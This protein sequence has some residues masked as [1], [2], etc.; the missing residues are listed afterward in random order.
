[1]KKLSFFVI[2]FITLLIQPVC[3]FSETGRIVIEGT[4]DSQALLRKLA[5]AFEKT[6]PGICIEIPDSIGSSGGIKATAS[7]KCDLGRVARPIKANEK[8]Y[9]L[10]FRCFAYAPVV[11]AMNQ[12]VRGIDNLTYSQ[13]LGI[14]SGE[15]E[16]WKSL[17]GPEGKIY[18]IN[19][20]QGDSSR[21]ALEETIPG[22]RNIQKPAGKTVYTTPEAFDILN[23]YEGTIG[24][25]PLAMIKG[26]NVRIPRINGI[27][28][29]TENVQEGKYP[30]VVPL[31]LVWKG[32]LNAH[33][34]AF[35]TFLFSPE[36]KK[37][38]EGNGAIPVSKENSDKIV[39]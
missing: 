39:P 21:T 6:H 36:G 29:S 27:E 10:T 19:R 18:I 34:S 7:G 25:V 38:I 26:S 22:F 35:V 11:F 14:Y 3:G 4:G 28:P 32:G 24:Y 30:N 37:I 1:M 33:S 17:G 2:C 16:D 12:S 20:E 31:G 23:Q 15:L 8:S 9:G 13:I 5:G